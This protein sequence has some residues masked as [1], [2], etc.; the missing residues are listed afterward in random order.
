MPAIPTSAQK[1]WA[2]T[3]YKGIEN[4]IFPSFTA[5][6]KAL[7]EAGIRHDVRQ[8]IAHGFVS[9]VCAIETGLSFDEV[10]L[11]LAIVA[12][13]AKGKILVSVNLICDT[14]DQTV[15]MMRHAERVGCQSALLGYPFHFRPDSADDI[16]RFSQKVCEA[17]GVNVLVY[18]SHKFNFGRLDPMGFP[19]AVIDRLLQIDNVVAVKMGLLEP[20]FIHEVYRRYNDHV[21]IEF[22]WE[23][24]WPLLRAQYKLQFAGAGAYEL[25][26]SPDKPLLVQMFNHLLADEMEDAMALYWRLTP[27]RMTFEQQFLPTQALGSYHWPQQKYYQFLTGGNGGY[28]RQPVMKLLQHELDDAKRAVQAIGIEP[29]DDDALFYQGRAAAGKVSA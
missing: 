25:F 8:S 17:A 6:F 24:W 20:G 9:T 18:P 4:C 2:W 13:E 28:T 21:V 14:L 7:D 3:H 27:V 1:Q 5:D 10:Q 29:T 15:E 23:R 19:L 11:M 22:P 12:D 26:Q 16:V